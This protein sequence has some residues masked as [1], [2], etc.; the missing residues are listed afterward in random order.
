MA[1]P[2]LDRVH[3][4][5]R[6]RVRELQPAVA[7]Y[8]QLQTADAALAGLALGQPRDGRAAATTPSAAPTPRRS[9]RRRRSTGTRA[10][11]GANR[12]A[13]LRVL[14]DRPD[15]GVAELASASGVGRTVLYGLLKTLEKRGD[16]TKE[17]LP[18]GATGY[19]LAQPAPAEPLAGPPK[20]TQ[21]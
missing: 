18:G 14:E 11:R 5:V 9:V 3:S 20:P 16:V 7:E 13:V 15:V 2:L 17:Q 4:E 19:R 8:E 21:S 12:A 10:P 1:E 6:A